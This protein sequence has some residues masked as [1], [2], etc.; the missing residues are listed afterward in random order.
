[1]NA[2]AIFAAARFN[3][4]GIVLPGCADD[5][6]I[7]RVIAE[8]ADCVGSIPDRSGKPGIDQERA[9]KFFDASAAFDAWSKLAEADAARVLPLGANTAA[10]ADAVKAVKSKVDDFF[11]RCRLAAFDPRSVSVLNRTEDAYIAIS[12]AELTIDATAVAGF[13]LA[14]IAA[15]KALPLKAGLN[16]AHAA[17]IAAL[18]AE[19]VQPLL[20][21]RAELTEA[22]WAEL[23][24]R[25]A[26]VRSLALGQ[27]RR[28]RR[29]TGPGPCP[30][31]SG[32]QSPRERQRLD[33]AGQS[34]RSGSDQRHPCR[35]VVALRARPLP[36]LPQFREL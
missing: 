25:L 21:N 1:M 4:D 36:A 34:R 17:K 13:P 31:P 5:P 11:G 28:G 14:Q 22:D 7:T 3:G 20:G 16:P 26:A 15:G 10:A 18:L 30:R 27:S 19:A 12:V 8:I 29:E 35:N 6:E 24:G 32:R 33:L 9:D 2:N 23:Q